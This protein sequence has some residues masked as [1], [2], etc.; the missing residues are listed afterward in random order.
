MQDNGNPDIPMVSVEVLGDGSLI[1]TDGEVHSEGNPDDVIPKLADN[2][3]NCLV[4]LQGSRTSTVDDVVTNLIS[5]G[6]TVVTQGDSLQNKY[7]KI[8][9][10]E[11]PCV[12]KVF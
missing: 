7:A 2:A 4:E 8:V 9:K 11:P 1:V 6:N 5:M 10:G 3:K 12:G